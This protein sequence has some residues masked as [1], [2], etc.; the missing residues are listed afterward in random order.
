M[1]L[2]GQDPFEQSS[3]VRPDLFCPMHHAGGRPLEMGLMALG[4]VFV[5][6]ADL[7]SAT[8]AEVRSH[9]LTPMK[10]LHGGRR[11]AYLYEFLYQVVRHAVEVRVEP[12]VIVDV[13]PSP[14]PL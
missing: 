2:V 10:D 1:R 13:H 12:D 4:P 8:A 14:G 7:A 9:S 6:G 11:G 3:G 5:L